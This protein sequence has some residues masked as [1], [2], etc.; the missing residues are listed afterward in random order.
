MNHSRF[1]KFSLVVAFGISGATQSCFAESNLWKK[2][3]EFVVDGNTELTPLPNGKKILRVKGHISE[4]QSV[5]PAACEMDLTFNENGNLISVD[6]SSEET[7]EP[8]PEGFR[9]YVH[10]ANNLSLS[11]GEISGPTV[12]NYQRTSSSLL[13]S[14]IDENNG[15]NA[16]VNLVKNSQGR[17][18]QLSF[19]GDHFYNPAEGLSDAYLIHCVVDAPVDL[20]EQKDATTMS[21]Q[22]MLLK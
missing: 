9:G 4:S 6:L 14:A 1:F 5:E 12:V 22:G 18:T 7:I 2:F 21:V 15:H 8:A 16:R 3:K 13:M 11:V 19:K 20:N 10:E 17:L